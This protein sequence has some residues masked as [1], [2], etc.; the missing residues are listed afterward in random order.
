MG[1][2][3]VYLKIGP[4][5]HVVAKG[6]GHRNKLGIPQVYI[7][8]AEEIVRQGIEIWN[9]PRNLHR[10]GARIESGEPSQPRLTGNRPAPRFV[11][12]MPKGRGYL[13]LDYDYTLVLRFLH[14]SFLSE[15]HTIASVNIP[16]LCQIFM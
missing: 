2:G 9:F 10:I 7:P 15:F 3:F 1:I 12:T 8:L 16:V 11:E 4:G 13:V 6:H 14:V 5:S